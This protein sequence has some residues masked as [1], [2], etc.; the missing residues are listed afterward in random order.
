MPSIACV[1]LA[2]GE[3][4][5][6]G[7]PKAFRT[8]AD[9]V[10]GLP[11]SFLSRVASVALAGGAW[12]VV[13]V[14]R[15]PDRFRAEAVAPPG[16]ALVVNPD[17]SRGMLSSLG[18]GVDAIPPEAPGLLVFP[19][20]HPEVLPGT[21]AALI[22][23]LRHDEGHPWRPCREGRC[24]HPVALPL[25]VAR[26]LPREDLPGGLAAW[27]RSRGLKWRDLPVPD[28]GILRNRNGPDP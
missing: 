6:A 3:G 10:S 1:I 21:V 18:C 12:P 4:R 14:V 23:A 27:V 26:E 24:G 13:A 5:R 28:P 15:P 22:E 20:D 11:E 16:L 7:G 9:P 17:P 25:A 8:F 2:A 19:V